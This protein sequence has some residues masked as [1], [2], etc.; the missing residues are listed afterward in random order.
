MTF[1]KER[2]NKGLISLQSRATY[3]L[4]LIRREH[5]KTGKPGVE[6]HARWGRTGVNI[7]ISTRKR[8]LYGLEEDAA[9]GSIRMNVRT[10]AQGDLG[11]P[12]KI[13]KT[14][15]RKPC[16]GNEQNGLSLTEGEGGRFLIDLTR[17]ERVKSGIKRNGTWFLG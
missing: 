13:S 4:L 2:L 3:S 16:R 14:K 11:V 1:S 17:T 15:R 8:R 12:R 5:Y 10:A 7:P 6:K 9:I